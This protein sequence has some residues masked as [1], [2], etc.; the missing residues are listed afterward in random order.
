MLLKRLLV[1]GV[2]L[3]LASTATALLTPAADA[4]PPRD[5]AGL[6]RLNEGSGQVAGDSSRSGNPGTLG[7]TTGVDGEDPTWLPL[8]GPRGLAPAALGFDGGDYVRVANAP[9]LEPD[10]VT[11]VARV[12]STGPGSFRYVLA[13]GALS[14]LTASYGLYTGQSGGLSFY[15]SDGQ[16]YTL[17]ADA[18]PRVW[19]GQ[20][21]TVVGGFDGH[22]VRLFVDGTQV[23]TG[24]PTTAPIGYGLPDSADL[25]IGDYAGPCGSPLGFVGDVDAV[26]LVGSYDRSAAAGLGG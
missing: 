10:G 22:S 13:K 25:F 23:G 24:V 2:A 11:V 5:L 1:S 26:A 9:S 20:W 8:P 12:R 21:H 6:W 19:D 15:V 7:S 17:S 18:G 16:D 3:A 4:A 14:C